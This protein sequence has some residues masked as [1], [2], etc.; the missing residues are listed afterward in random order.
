[1]EEKK[2]EI[3]SEL[4]KKFG[5]LPH[6]EPIKITKRDDNQSPQNLNPHY[7]SGLIDGDGSIFFSFRSTVRRVIASFTITMDIYDIS[8]LYDVQNLLGSGKVYVLKTNAA[9]FQI[10]SAKVLLDT[11][12]PILLK[13]HLN[14][15]KQ[16]Y[17]NNSVKA[18]E[19][20][21]HRKIKDDATLIE[22][23]KL[24]YDMNR[25]GKARKMSQAQYLNKWIKP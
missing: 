16:S 24:V 12:Y 6:F 3:T 7:F 22:V 9:R 11:L 4:K 18:W 10:D 5:V 8:I 13:G 1:M 19:I 14:T 2:N 17:L 23:V 20:L 15:V 21:A 25:K